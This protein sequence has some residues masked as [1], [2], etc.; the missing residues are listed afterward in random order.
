MTGSEDQ[1]S[2][3]TVT[4]DDENDDIDEGDWQSIQLGKNLL[5]MTMKTTTLMKVIGR[6]SS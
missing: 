5:R 3:R 1:L 4:D 6:V 2:W